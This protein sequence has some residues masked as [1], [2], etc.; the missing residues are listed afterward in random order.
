MNVLLVGGGGAC[1][2]DSAADAVSLGTLAVM[3]FLWNPSCISNRFLIRPKRPTSDMVNSMIM[4]ALHRS[5][6]RSVKAALPCMHACMHGS[7]KIKGGEKVMMTVR[8]T[9][10]CRVGSSIL[11][12]IHSIRSRFDSIRRSLI[13]HEICHSIR[14]FKTACCCSDARADP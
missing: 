9:T 6:D 5:E 8:A 11:V 4:M 10:L 1:V 7:I 2:V 14:S 13:E 3:R 12:R